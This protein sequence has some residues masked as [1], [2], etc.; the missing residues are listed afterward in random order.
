MHDDVG[1]EFEGTAQ[2]RRGKCV[3]DD[4]RDTGVFRDRRDRRDVE[5]VDLRIA[6]GL[7]I[8]QF[9]FLGDRLPE[10]LRVV[11]IDELGVDAEFA[12]VHFEERIGAAIERARRND[13][14][15]LLA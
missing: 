13:L 15:A 4:E 1:P 14:V 8:K 9:G 11:G 6:D 10:I 5:H 3:V 2:I 12:Q 7:G